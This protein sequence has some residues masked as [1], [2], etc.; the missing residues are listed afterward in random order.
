MNFIN[1]FDLLEV[2]TTDNDAIK[3]AKR[4]KLADI[5]LNDGFLEIGNQKISRSE[6]IKLADELDDNKKKKMYFF[7]KNGINLNKLLLNGDIR[8]FYL[9]QPHKAY[10]NQ[11]FINFVSPYFAES[12]NQLLLKAFKTGNHT[13]VNKLF[14]VPLLVNQ[15]HTDKLYKNLSR[16]L[17]EQ[18]EE[19]QDIKDNIDEDV[20]DIIDT[21]E[22]IIDIDSLNSLP[23]YFQKQR[24]DIATILR[25]ISVDVFNKFDNLQIACNI[26]NHALKIEIDGTTKI[27]LNEAL[28]QLNDI[29]EKQKQ[30][31]KE[32]K[33]FQAWSDVLSKIRSLAEDV[34]NTDIDVDKI[35]AR[36]KDLF[37]TDELNKLPEQFEEIKHIIVLSLRNLSVDVSNKYKKYKVSILII[38]IAQKI[39]IKDNELKEKLNNDL[40]ILQQNTEQ[41]SFTTQKNKTEQKTQPER[42]TTQ[43][44]LSSPQPKSESSSIG[45]WFAFG[46]LVLI[47]WGL[48]QSSTPVP[49]AK[50]KTIVAS[51]P[52]PVPKSQAVTE[53]SGCI[54]NCTN[55]YGTFIYDNG[56]KYEG[57]WKDTKQ[58]GQGTMIIPNS[59]KYI[60][61]W[62]NGNPDGHGTIISPNGDKY[63]SQ[64]KD[65]IPE[66]QVTITYQNG[67]SYTGEN[68]NG[69]PEGQGTFIYSNGDKYIGKFK[70]GIRNGKGNYFVANGTQIKGIW[71]NGQLTQNSSSTSRRT[72][73][74]REQSEIQAQEREQVETQVQQ[75]D[76]SQARIWTEVQAREQSEAQA[77]FLSLREQAEANSR[78]LGL[79]QQAEDEKQRAETRAWTE[80][81][82]DARLAE[83]QTEANRNKE[84]MQDKEQRDRDANFQRLKN[85]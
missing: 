78:A 49:V 41:E 40:N 59:N 12:F 33:V 24:N 16:L 75:Q 70:D 5:E 15:E 17:S 55:G 54:G 77:K 3:K 1:P 30:A 25:H 8:F 19:L 66:K 42:K 43:T 13:I 56:N 26:I 36:I 47:V 23:S 11:D 34:E 53:N 57:D 52:T 21:F 74:A 45:G 31:E 20:S 7:I 84:Y 81:Q 38:N 61:E 29:G 58:E 83:S 9:Y 51:K 32:Q 2:E 44:N 76:E 10:Q 73:K 68:K 22:S 82:A 48:M 69:I 4:R 60:G 64:W 27:R 46:F 85:Y 39:D 71:K 14:S 65:G 79:R 67:G 62:K 72:T 28:K 63:V 18:L 35:P 50:E 80:A 6:F 37:S